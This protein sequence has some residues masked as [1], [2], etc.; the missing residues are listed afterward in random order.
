MK[1]KLKFSE[2]SQKKKVCTMLGSMSPIWSQKEKNTDLFAGICAYIGIIFLYKYTKNR[3]TENWQKW[4]SYP[5][6]LN[7]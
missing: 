7:I 4:N 2:L 1:P 5:G 6:I 3:V